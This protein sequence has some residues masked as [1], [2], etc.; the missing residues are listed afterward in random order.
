MK[1]RTPRWFW[2]WGPSAGRV[3]VQVEVQVGSGSQPC[4]TRTENAAEE[5]RGLVN[6]SS[7]RKIPRARRK[8]TTEKIAANFHSAFRTSP[9]V[10]PA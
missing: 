6:A 4:L 7:T 3:P 10:A 5:E 2:G 8:K 1:G 9:S